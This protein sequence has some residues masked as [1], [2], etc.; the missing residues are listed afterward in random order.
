MGYDINNDLPTVD[1]VQEIYW[2]AEFPD[3]VLEIDPNDLFSLQARLQDM[4]DPDLTPLYD[5]VTALTS[6]LAHYPSLAGPHQTT[7]VE[8][9]TLH[10]V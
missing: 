2:L 3:A 4:D 7:R 10:V 6:S 5:T 8:P 9:K 1:I